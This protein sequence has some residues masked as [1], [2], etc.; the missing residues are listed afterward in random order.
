[1]I[2][3]SVPGIPVPKG[4]PRFSISNGFVRAHTPAITVNYETLVRLSAQRA[5]LGRPPLSGPVRLSIQIVL[6]VPTSWSKEKQRKALAGE[7]MPT[8]KPDMD[9]VVKALLDGMNSVVF[10]DDSN[11][12]DL[13]VSKRYG[14]V[15]RADIGAFY[16]EGSAA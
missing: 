14:Q 9:N 3:F 5:M 2:T 12:V 11:V 15:P 10:R 16:V 7:V 1:M 8:K 13:N 4:R 6:P